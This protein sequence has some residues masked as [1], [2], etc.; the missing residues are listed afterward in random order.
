MLD[1]GERDFNY[2]AHTEADLINPLDSTNT[3]MLHLAARFD[4]L[5]PVSILLI[6]K[7]A[8]IDVEDA[9]GETLPTLQLDT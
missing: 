5:L 4:F 8:R 6:E 3:T 1:R 2:D 9:K 7:G